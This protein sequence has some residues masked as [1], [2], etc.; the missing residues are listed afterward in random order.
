MKMFIAIFVIVVTVLECVASLKFLCYSPRFASSHV[1]FMGKLADSLIDAG[2]EVVVLS[3]TLDSTVPEG[4]KRARLIQIPMTEA[5]FEFETGM[6]ENLTEWQVQWTWQV[7]GGWSAYAPLWVAQCH[8]EKFDAAFAESIDWCAVGIF[9][10]V[11]I[12][13]FAI[14]ESFA[15]KDGLYPVSGMD[16]NLAYVP[17]IMGGHF[18]EEMSFSQRAFNVFNY[19]IYKDFVYHAVD[20]YQTM[21]DEYQ[22]G[23]PGVVDL[24]ALNS[25]YFLNSDPLVDFPRPSAAR[26]IDIGGV[27][28]SNGHKELNETWSSILSLRP[29]TVL[30]SFGTL[31]KAYSMPEEYKES[32][33][34]TARAMPDVTFIWKY[35]RP[36]HN[37]SQ[38]IP[39]L[40][41]ATW[42]PQNDMLNDHRLSL[43][44]THCGQGSTTEANYAGVPL[45]IVPV[46]LDQIRNAYAMER[47]GL[48]VV[49]EKSQ[50]ATP[51]T[52]MDAVKKVMEDE[53]YKKRALDTAQML[54]EKP[55][56]GREL[57]VRN[58][59]FL[60]VHGP[61]RQLDHYGRELSF[62]QY[63]AID[64][65][66]ALLITML[67]IVGVV[68][69]IVY[70]IVKFARK[71]LSVKAKT[72]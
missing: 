34:A 53:S 30:M 12:D 47:R 16:I 37:V 8:Q 32:I 44:V 42:V 25:L 14:T 40:I 67:S 3:P 33:R 60:A 10:L 2:H 52:F 21:F 35:E 24:M 51:K 1:N 71:T 55:F 59:E 22:K 4:T 41:E 23:F 31:A 62:I 65:I 69:Y 26:V 43:F 66:G 7:I 29:R 38:G 20:R 6:N 54:R 18:G 46:V 70:R 15:Q 57:F 39:N 58:M 13:K 27:A 19:F 36:S 64:V 63:Y 49:V 5:S 61:L 28:V 68:G 45:V 48:G 56:T 11:G 17:T 9:H 72:Q 50:L